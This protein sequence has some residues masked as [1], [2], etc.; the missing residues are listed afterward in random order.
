[1]WGLIAIGSLI[2]LPLGMGLALPRKWAI[3]LLVSLSLVFFWRVGV[4]TGFRSGPE[5]FWLGAGV[6][7]MFE[8][9][10]ALI[11]G[12]IRKRALEGGTPDEVPPSELEA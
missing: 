1:M 8:I 3:P 10:M 7:T 6:V 4:Y 2:A 9:N 12:W 5:K 11:G